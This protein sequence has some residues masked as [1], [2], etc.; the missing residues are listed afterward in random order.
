MKRRGD[1][2]LFELL[3]SLI[4]V[5]ASTLGLMA[6]ARNYDQHVTRERLFP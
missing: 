2:D 3:I 5:A 4:L 1:I 6:M